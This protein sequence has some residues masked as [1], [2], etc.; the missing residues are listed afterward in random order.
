MLTHP[1]FD[2][3]AISLGPVQVHWYGLMYLAGFLFVFYTGKRL[4][5]QQRVPFAADQVDDLV[6]YVALGVIF[7][8]RFGYVLFYDFDQ[9]LANPL[10]LLQVWKGGMS[11]HGGFL[12]VVLALIYFAKKNQYPVGA[13]FDFAAIAAPIGLGLGRLGNFIGQE[14]WGRASDVPWAMVF[15]ADPTGLARHPSQL[16]EAMGEGFL[17]FLLIYW[18]SSKPRPMWSAGALFI[19]GYGLARFLVEFF[20]E[21]DSHIGF[22]L[23][24]W[25]SRGQ[26]LSLP[27]ILIGIGVMIWSYKTQ[28]PFSAINSAKST[29][30]KN[31]NK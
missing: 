25:M 24:G 4:A 9:F 20:R 26:I 19:I 17:L 2:P 31:T 29:Q 23:F 28:T 6:F 21:P 13:I 5:N 10:W 11:F 8:G 16:Y 30:K 18:Y 7:G 15:P 1:A 12:G 22:D 14:L 3:V 27:M